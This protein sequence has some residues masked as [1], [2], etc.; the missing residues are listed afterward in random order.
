MVEPSR[1][2]GWGGPASTPDPA[3]FPQQLSGPE[4]DRRH[5]L[6]Y[7]GHRSRG[8]FRACRTSSPVRFRCPSRSRAGSATRSVCAR[9]DTA[10]RRSARARVH[11]EWLPRRARP[12]IRSRVPGLLPAAHPT[13][14]INGFAGYFFGNGPLSP[15][16]RSLEQHPHRVMLPDT[17]RISDAQTPPGPQRIASRGISPWWSQCHHFAGIPPAARASAAGSSSFRSA[18]RPG[19]VPPPLPR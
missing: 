4:V 5:M 14:V 10:C 7:R 9:A 17:A 15:A 16:A 6:L 3:V 2:V 1:R 8:P 12:E 11:A 13:S 18:G 19:Q